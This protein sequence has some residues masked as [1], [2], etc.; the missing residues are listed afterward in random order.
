MRVFCDELERQALPGYL[1]TDRPEN[2]RFYARFG[3]EVI[4]E[5]HVLG[6]PNFFMIRRS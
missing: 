3:F 1:E 2:I 6:V 4:A 5:Q